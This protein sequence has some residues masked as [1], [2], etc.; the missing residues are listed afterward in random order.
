MVT[1]KMAE[2]KD[3]TAG[4]GREFTPPSPEPEETQACS[5]LGSLSPTFCLCHHLLLLSPRPLT[6]ASWL[7][8]ECSS[9]RRW[10]SLSCS[11]A[12]SHP[13]RH[14]PPPHWI[15]V[16]ESRPAWY[17]DAGDLNSDPHACTVN[18]LTHWA[19]SPAYN[20]ELLR[21]TYFCV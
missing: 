4:N 18:A 16:M 13:V 15:A 20:K 8:P 7:F 21:F 9:S 12:G 10:P 17:L 2:R 1:K 11:S 19:I 6:F 5:G 14:S 3:E